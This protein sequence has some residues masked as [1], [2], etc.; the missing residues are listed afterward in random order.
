MELI[1]VAQRESATRREGEAL[2]KLRPAGLLGQQGYDFFE[3]PHMIANPCRHCWRFVDAPVRFLK[4][5][6]G[7]A[8]VVVHE[9]ERHGV[10][11]VLDLSWRRR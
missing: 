6:V 4:R 11:V 9:V 5:S 8:K 3:R 10:L 2:L 7:A 1:V